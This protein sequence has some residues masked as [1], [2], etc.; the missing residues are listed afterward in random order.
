VVWF[1]FETE[2]AAMFEWLVITAVIIIIV[3][4]NFFYRLVHHTE[5]LKSLAAV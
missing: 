5:K 3:I 2:T 4:S 1:S